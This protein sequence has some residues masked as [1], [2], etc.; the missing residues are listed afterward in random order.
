MGFSF[1][2]LF[3]KNNAEKA[4]EDTI[5]AIIS[6]VEHQ[7]YGV[8][9]SNVLFS[10]LNELGG[11]LFFQ[12]VIVGTLNVKCKNGAKLTFK[13]KDFDLTLASDSLEF[14]SNH[15][16]TKGRYVTNIDFQIEEA[17]IKALEKAEL[18]EIKLKVK[19]HEILFTK[20]ETDNK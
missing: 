4:T 8:S 9:E 5:E 19:K 17:E 1:S 15:T 14:E 3:N 11:Y 6:S 7:P 12:T 16:D 13:G 20:H 18:K 10:G 2:K